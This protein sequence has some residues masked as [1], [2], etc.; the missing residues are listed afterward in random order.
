M[1]NIIQTVQENLQYPPLHKIQSN[2]KIGTA[3]NELTEIGKLAQSA[4]PAVLAA[5]Y[6]FSKIPES[7]VQLKRHTENESNWLPLLFAEN[8][9][10]VVDNISHYSGISTN[11]TKSHLQIIT[12]ESIKLIK[13]NLGGN[14]SDADFEKWMKDQR[15]TILVYLVPELGIGDLLND[16]SLEDPTNKMEAPVSDFMH[17]IENNFS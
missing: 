12:D 13:E 10:L 8:E 11:R 2:G 3:K 6:R 14:P 17:K 15:H 7:G 16:E 5:L 9:N 1:E 4:I